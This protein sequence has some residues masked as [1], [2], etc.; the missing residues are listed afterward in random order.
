MGLI[1][2]LP[3]P[4]LPAVLKNL[5]DQ[6]AP[7]DDFAKSLSKEIDPTGAVNEH[8]IAF[9]EGTGSHRFRIGSL[10]QWLELMAITGI[11][12]GTT[13]SMTLLFF[14]PQ[15]LSYVGAKPGETPAR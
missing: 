1:I 11:I 9:C 2:D 7:I 14:L 15:G 8:M 13:F 4:G 3:S 6:A 5:A 12:H 10:K